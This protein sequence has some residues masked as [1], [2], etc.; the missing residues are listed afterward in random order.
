VEEEKEADK[1][2]GAILFGAK[3]ATN[4]FAEIGTVFA[5]VG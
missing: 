2:T 5:L 4:I 3:L 1:G